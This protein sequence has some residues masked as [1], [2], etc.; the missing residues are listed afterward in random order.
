MKTLKFIAALCVLSMGSELLAQQLDPDT[1]KDI[2]EVMEQNKDAKAKRR[3]V[4][5]SGLYAEYEESKSGS[6]EYS[7]YLSG[8]FRRSQSM[9]SFEY[10]L[11]KTYNNK[12]DNYERTMLQIGARYEYETNAP[13]EF[14]VALAYRD[15]MVV[16]SNSGSTTGQNIHGYRPNFTG[17]YSFGDMVSVYADLLFNFERRAQH[18]SGDVVEYNDYEHELLG[19]ISFKLSKTH[20]FN[21][22]YLHYIEDIVGTERSTLSQARFSYTYNFENGLSL[23]PYYRN[24][25]DYKYEEYTGKYEKS[26]TQDGLR[27]YYGLK[28]KYPVNNRV[29]V[30]GNYYYRDE[31][32]ETFS[33]GKKVNNYKHYG[34]F[35][36]N[37]NY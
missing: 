22:E 28:F 10:D 29:T 2:L 25:F 34:M 5:N 37:Y 16:S 18:G 1:K 23:T 24:E 4:G 17:S 15:E 21:L 19:G 7:P 33:T 30:L 14:G 8:N 11:Y 13:Y 12:N 27:T 3:W 9:F 32:W 31:E 35:G 26:H 36:F 20:Q 6:G